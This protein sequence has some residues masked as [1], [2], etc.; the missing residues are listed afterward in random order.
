MTEERLLTYK[1]HLWAK[2]LADLDGY[3][4]IAVVKEGIE[5]IVAQAREEGTTLN[6][7][8]LRMHLDDDEPM[9]MTQGVDLEIRIR[10]VRET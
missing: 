7:K 1:Q 4:L 3:P 2:E 6:W 10:G 8:S 5:G 9:G